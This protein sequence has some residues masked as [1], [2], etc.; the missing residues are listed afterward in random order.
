MYYAGIYEVSDKMPWRNY[1]GFPVQMDPDNMKWRDM[2]NR[3]QLTGNSGYSIASTVSDADAKL[4]VAFF[5]YCASDEGQMLLQW[6]IEGEHY[7]WDK[8]DKSKDWQGPQSGLYDGNDPRGPRLVDPEVWS[9]RT[10]ANTEVAEMR[11]KL[12]FK[13]GDGLIGARTILQNGQNLGDYPRDDDEYF[14]S[15]DDASKEVFNAYGIK[16]SNQLF[17]PGYPWNDALPL[18]KHGNAY[19]LASGLTEVTKVAAAHYEEAINRDI[20]RAIVAP[21]AQFDAEWDRFITGLDNSN[22]PALEEEMT[23]SLK[24]RMEMWYGK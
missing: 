23:K 2:Q 17:P 16:G 15:R 12:G 1:L 6:G 22:L 10:S 18:I 8:N 14:D 24:E 19:N 3:G 7:T 4:L 20:A 9:M 11:G 5:D 21:P 13:Y